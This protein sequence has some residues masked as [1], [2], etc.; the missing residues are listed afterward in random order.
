MF[1][2]YSER[3][4]KLYLTVNNFNRLHFHS[5]NRVVPGVAWCIDNLVS[6][7]HSLNHL[8]KSS[9]L[10]VQKMRGFDHDEK[11]G[12]GTVGVL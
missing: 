10:I 6:N 12:A 2:K 4:K 1:L 5:I 3:R 11:L 7:T 9:E 8:A